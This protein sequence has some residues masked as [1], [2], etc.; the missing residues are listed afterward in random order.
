MTIDDTYMSDAAVMPPCLLWP[1]CQPLD[2]VRDY[3]GEEVGFYFAWSGHMNY[4]LLFPAIVGFA[5]QMLLLF[6]GYTWCDYGLTSNSYF[7]AV[8]S[9]VTMLWMVYYKNSWQ[10]QVRK[11]AQKILLAYVASARWLFHLTFL[12]FFFPFDSKS[13]WHSGGV[14]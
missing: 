13:S 6:S 5:N 8:T 7:Q 12:V 9:I 10:A 11:R 4:L 1:F 3:F 2:A 14:P